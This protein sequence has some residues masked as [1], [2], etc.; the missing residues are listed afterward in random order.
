MYGTGVNSRYIHDLSNF[1]KT[2]L[3]YAHIRGVRWGI[4]FCDAWSSILIF[5]EW[6]FWKSIFRESWWGHCLWTVLIK[7]NFPSTVIETSQ[8]CNYI[9][10]HVYRT[11]QVHWGKIHNDRINMFFFI[12]YSRK[13]SS[14]K[15]ETKMGEARSGMDSQPI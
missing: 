7:N 4:K 6:W 8:D 15:S 14:R 3:N 1:L 12:I 2:G 9:V 13:S 11:L 10:I 5:P